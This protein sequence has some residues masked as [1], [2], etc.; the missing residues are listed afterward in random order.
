MSAT[1]PVSLPMDVKRKLLAA[2]DALAVGD[3]MEAHHQIYSIASPHFNKLADE[4]WTALETPT[5]DSPGGASELQGRQWAVFCDTCGAT[6]SVQHYH[7]GKDRC[8]KCRNSSGETSEEQPEAEPPEQ[9]EDAP[10]F[11]EAELFA[12]RTRLSTNERLVEELTASVN[13]WKD[14]CAALEQ[15]LTSSGEPSVERE[16]LHRIKELVCGEARPRWD[17]SPETTSTRGVIADICDIGL[18]ARRAPEPGGDVVP[19]DA[20]VKAVDCIR[21][22]HNTGI[23]A[24][25]RSELWDIYWRNSPEM[26]PIREA[27]ST[28][29]DYAPVTELTDYPRNDREQP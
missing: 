12:A 28:A 14:R 9:L 21:E 7:A 23:P 22:W 16:A 15:R 1:D 3:L 4:V 10:S 25:H 13:L 24:K 2:R 27:L 6:W 17:N 26:K 29:S 8:E 19:R 20:L 5:P 11:L 18:N